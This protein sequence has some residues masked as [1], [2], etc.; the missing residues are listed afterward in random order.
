MLEAFAEEVWIATGEPCDVAGFSYPTRSVVVRLSNGALWVWSP[1]TLTDALRD[2]LAKLGPVAHLVA[3]NSFHHLSMGAW[4]QAFPDAQTYGT[5]TLIAKRSDLR[6][7]HPL[8]NGPAPTW[9]DEIAVQVVVNKLTTEAVFFHRK[10]GTV[11]VTDLLQQFDKGF[12]RGWRSLVARLDLMTGE[13]PQVPRKFR[14]GFSNRKR[15]RAE[16]APILDWPAD[17]LIVAHGAP[18]LGGAYQ[19]LRQS[20]RWLMGR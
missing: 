13:R 8:D 20:F 3:P 6:W 14:L 17:N 9:V 18:V 16:I 5:A 4:Q 1:S 12:H 15:A 19:V 10:S 11:L 7:D 2:A